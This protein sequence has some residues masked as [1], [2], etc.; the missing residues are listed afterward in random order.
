VIPSIPFIFLGLFL[1]YFAIRRVSLD[2]PGAS[3]NPLDEA[4]SPHGGSEL[5]LARAAVVSSRS[6]AR[7]LPQG[8][9]PAAC[10]VVAVAIL[11]VVLGGVWADALGLGVAYAVVFLSYSISAGEGGM[12]WLC[13]I[14]FAGIGALTTAELA[15]HGWPLLL[16][17]LAGGL[18]CALLGTIIAALT[19]RLG[20]LY[21][22]LLTLVFGL[23]V[24]NM[25]F[26]LQSLDGDGAGLLVSRPSF[27]QGEA[28]F[29]WFALAV[30]VIIALLFANLRR[31]TFGLAVGAA[32]WSNRG[33]RATGVGVVG[34]KVA[35]S[36]FAAFVAGLG[37]GLLA[38]YASA[39]VPGS[40]ATLAGL[41]WLAVVVTVGVRSASA[42]LLAGLAFSFLPELVSVYLP[43]SWGQ[44]PAALFGLGAILVARNPE[45]TL[46][47]Q[48]RQVERLIRRLHPERQQIP[49]QM[50]LRSSPAP[51]DSEI[52]S[53]P[54]PQERELLG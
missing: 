51:C 35:L 19:V 13:Q 5:A 52:P 25:V 10:A 46:A 36:T 50:A 49:L 41:I 17:L 31:S 8:F 7:F 16:A 6:S 43:I 4:I 23:L 22:T 40:Y 45:G 44:V 33:A 53:S 14:T 15:M 21:L 37:G 26:S 9:L 54:V 38:M 30:F 32:R 12:V 11:P 39:A 18:L 47:T 2:D 42:A 27:A 24:E 3:G 20:D 29:T 34:T 1:V 48:A 28:G